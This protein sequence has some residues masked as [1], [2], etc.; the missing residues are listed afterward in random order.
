[1]TDPWVWL[2]RALITS[3]REEVE[4]DLKA[5]RAQMWI[6]QRSA[7]VTMLHATPEPHIHV[8]LGGG[9]MQELI[10]LA[11]GLEAWARAHG[12]VAATIDGRAGWARVLR[13]HGWKP[14]GNELRKAL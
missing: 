6:G 7:M 9:D 3:T 14:S 8:W 1:M 13:H 5:S 11:P 10:Y 4:A 2:E 12:C